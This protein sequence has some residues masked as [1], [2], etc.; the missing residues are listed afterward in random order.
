MA[1]IDGEIVQS[2]AGGEINPRLTVGLRAYGFDQWPPYTEIV[3]GSPQGS[4]VSALPVEAVPK[5]LAGEVSQA[6]SDDWYHRIHIRP[7]VLA[8]GNIAST[9]AQEIEVWNA[10]LAPVTLLGIDGIEEGMVL[11]GAFDFPLPFNALQF[12]TWNLS[13][14]EEGPSAIDA[15]L[16]W[17]FSGVP[18]AALSI[19]GTRIVTW[20]ILPDWGDGIKERLEWATEVM[21]SEERDE[22]RRALRLS[23]RRA[24]D[25]RMVFDGRERS[26]F[27]LATHGWGGR[28][29]AMPVWPDIQLLSAPVAAGALSIACSTVGR[30]FREG[31]LALLYDSAF[32][33]EVCEIDTVTTGALTLVR[34]TQAAWPT[35]TRLYPVRTARFAEQPK[36][37]RLT[38]VAVD[39]NA[40]FLLA[41]PSDW[42]EA[43]LPSY[44]GFPVYDARPDE[45][46]ELTG[47][48]ERMLYQL[49]NT[50]GLP[51][52]LDTAEAAFGTQ[53]HRW[54]L[55]GIDERSA[56]RSLLYALR[57]QQVSVW[58]PTHSDDL[59]IAATV[60]SA[61]VAMVIENVGYARFGQGQRGRQDI[62]IELRSGVVFYRRIVAA[63]AIDTATEQITIDSVLGVVVE[64][65]DVRRISFMMLARSTSDTTEILHV[66]DVLGVATSRKIFVGVK[67]E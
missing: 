66:N 22:Q 13:I 49:D 39:V 67:D 15:T 14:D 40:T 33:S 23:P 26:L 43:V 17:V 64:P 53:A 37:R 12:K 46:E 38:D 27:D 7:K 51:F 45:T 19:T 10:W 62:R 34:P 47:T 25:V 3:A 11:S 48:F 60:G 57:G 42:P 21:S 28:V 36:V 16:T 18:S 1:V 5:T 54:V 9:Q 44:R 6:L 63:A 52:V 41:E 32:A 29:W 58:L 20:P 65:A 4:L 55:Q 35:R 31:G 30:D 8:L 61:A 2:G 50:S 56:F 24:F 59:R